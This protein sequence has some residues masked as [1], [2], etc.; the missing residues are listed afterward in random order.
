MIRASLMFSRLSENKRKFLL[1]DPKLADLIMNR[2]KVLL[3]GR[4]REC[5]K[6]LRRLVVRGERPIKVSDSWFSAKII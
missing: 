3:E 6:I 5:C 4:T 1:L 2:P